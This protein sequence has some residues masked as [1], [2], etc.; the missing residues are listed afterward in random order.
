MARITHQVRKILR[1][2]IYEVAEAKRKAIADEFSVIDRKI[3]ERL[4]SSKAKALKEVEKEL[5]K[6]ES[7]VDDI[8]AK[9][10]LKFGKGY[11]NN[12]YCICNIINCEDG[13]TV[14]ESSAPSYIVCDEKDKDKVKYD[15]LKKKLNDIDEAIERACNDVEFRISL[16]AKFNEVVE[17][18]SGLKF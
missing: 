4:A 11:R 10:G 12:R 18:I 13:R 6:L 17:I 15:E 8:L 2:K 3:D 7:T 1:A 16:G 14:L 9:H 5:S